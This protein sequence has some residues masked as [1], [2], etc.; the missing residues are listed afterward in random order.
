MKKLYAIVSR[1]R[2][3]KEIEFSVNEDGFYIIETEF[4][5]LMTM[6]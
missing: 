1:N 2:E 6:G 5:Y 4:V 3:G